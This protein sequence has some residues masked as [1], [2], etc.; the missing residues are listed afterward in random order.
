MPGHRLTVGFVQSLSLWPWRFYGM[1]ISL[2]FSVVFIKEC[3]QYKNLTNAIEYFE[4]NTEYILSKTMKCLHSLGGYYY[5]IIKK[6]ENFRLLIQT[7]NI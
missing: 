4:C 2:L 5:W 3:L 6:Q 7:N 1:S